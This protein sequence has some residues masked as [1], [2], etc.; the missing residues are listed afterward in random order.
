MERIQRP[1]NDERLFF[2]LPRHEKEQFMRKVYQSGRGMADV[3]RA[4]VRKFI[5]PD[6][7]V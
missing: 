1:P 5:R 7:R 6:G 2:Q 3:L 4:L